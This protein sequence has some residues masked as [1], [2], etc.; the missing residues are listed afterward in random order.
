MVNQTKERP[1]WPTYFMEIAYLVSKRST[2]LR[3]KVGA[4]IVRDKQIISTGYNGSPRKT[5]HCINL[6]CLRKEMGIETGKNHELC[7]GSHAELNAIVQAAAYG[8]A[9]EGA[10]IYSTSEP[11]VF[12]TKAIINAGIHTIYYVQEYEDQ[13]AR[14]LRVE[15]GIKMVKVPDIFHNKQG[16]VKESDFE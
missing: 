11:C 3:R 7:R 16:E 10:V 13:L 4:V 15:A 5:R 1:A 6:G 2:C 8:I 14:Q 9:V 12:C